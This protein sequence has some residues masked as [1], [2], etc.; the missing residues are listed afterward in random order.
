MYPEIGR[1]RKQKRNKG[2]RGTKNLTFDATHR[3]RLW[4]TSQAGFTYMQYGIRAL[5]L[6][7][8]PNTGRVI[9]CPN[10]GLREER[11]VHMESTTEPN[12]SVFGRL[13]T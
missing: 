1:T 13:L 9:R 12:H 7:K 8:D 4:M 3:G 2:D 5:L 10:G 6:G 11:R